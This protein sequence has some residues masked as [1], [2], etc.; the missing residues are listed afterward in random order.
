MST[1]ALKNKAITKVAYVRRLP[2]FFALSLANPGPQCDLNN[3][4]RPH[5]SNCYKLNAETRK[6]WTEARADCVL[7]GGDLVSI[8]SAEEEQYVTATLDPSRIDLWIGFS[9]LV[10]DTRCLGLPHCKKP[11][12]A[13][14]PLRDPAKIPKD[15]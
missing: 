3:G 2:G 10:R 9:T 6:S 7:Q 14:S 4:W 11:K 8:T 15:T 1:V 5:G 12:L 13:P